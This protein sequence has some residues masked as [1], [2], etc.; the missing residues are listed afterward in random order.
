[1]EVVSIEGIAGFQQDPGTPK[2]SLGY[3]LFPRPIAL[4]YSLCL[5]SQEATPHVVSEMDMRRSKLTSSCQLA[6][7][8]KGVYFLS[9]YLQ[10]ES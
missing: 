9:Q 6:I 2:I 1:M 5:H 7:S 8:V 10:Q 4:P 3:Y